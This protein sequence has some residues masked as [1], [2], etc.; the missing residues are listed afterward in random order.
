M[1]LKPG[2][3]RQGLPST[4]QRIQDVRV[5]FLHSLSGLRFVAALTVVVSLQS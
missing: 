1:I 3:L 2:A 5:V 4:V